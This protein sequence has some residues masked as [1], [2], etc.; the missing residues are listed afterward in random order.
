MA[1]LKM[2]LCVQPAVS[3]SEQG[4]MDRKKSHD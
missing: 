2:G 4:H 3:R 1:G